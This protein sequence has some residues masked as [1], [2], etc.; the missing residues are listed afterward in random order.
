MLMG[1][2]NAQRLDLWAEVEAYPVSGS[3]V[4]LRINNKKNKIPSHK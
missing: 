1:S 3:N 4:A 2:G